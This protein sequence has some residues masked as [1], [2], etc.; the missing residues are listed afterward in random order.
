MGKKIIICGLNGA[1]KS[2]LGKLLAEKTGYAFADIEDYYFPQKNVYENARTE[3]EVTRLLLSDML[4]ND[5]FIL[6]AV[7]GN[8][9]ADIEKLFTHAVLLKVPKPVRMERIRRRSFDKFGERSLEGGE[10]YESEKSFFDMVE[11]RPDNLSEQ[12]LDNLNIPTITIDGTQPAEQSV[13]A[14]MKFL[15]G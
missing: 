10:L 4:K 14:V 3:D 13:E 11:R 5:N 9:S 6:S 8:Y 15:T 2:T 1:G 7:R 12:W